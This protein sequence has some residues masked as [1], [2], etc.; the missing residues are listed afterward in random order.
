MR[1]L[2]RNEDGWVMVTAVI[3]MSLMMSFGL[4]AFS[5]VDTQTNVSKKQRNDESSFNLTEGALQQQGY[6]LGFN[7]PAN[8]AQAFVTC[9]YGAG[10]D[11]TPVSKCPQPANLT[12]G[13]FNQVDY[14]AQAAWKTQV[15]DNGAPGAGSEFY[16]DRTAATWDA[17]G[18]GKLWVK[19]SSTVRGKSRTIVALLKRE[20][21]S[22]ALPSAVVKADHFAT[23]NNGNKV[24]IDSTGGQIIV[25]CQTVPSGKPCADYQES[26]GQI[27]PP[28]SIVQE[29]PQTTPT[30]SEAQLARFKTVAQSSNPPTYYTS[31]P[32][33]LTGDAVYI[34]VP[35]GTTCSFTGNSV[36]NSQQNPG[37]VIMPKG[38]M[39]LGGGV[40]YYGVM[41]FGNQ[42]PGTT[43]AVLSIGG[44]ATVYG[45]VIIDGGGGLDVG[46]S[47]SGGRNLANLKYDPNAF[48]D[49]TTFGTAGLIQ[50]TW[51]EL[52][53]EPV[54]N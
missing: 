33:S 39:T 13:N 44:N 7:W 21:L 53:P 14:A 43:G 38:K 45:G 41:Y 49:I 22:E 32:S 17:N 46:S 25:R 1:R 6:V 52:P 19:S 28:G 18:D 11:N 35:S 37:F 31:C 2:T 42:A 4:A 40:T 23:T 30:M 3:V 47:G 26:K 8:A 27:S 24:I 16:E 10:A 12:G 50:N 20:K 29:P 51:R 54:T 9:S 36:F 34:D 5:T 15:N 48:R